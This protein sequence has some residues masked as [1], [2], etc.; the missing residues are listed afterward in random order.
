MVEKTESKV[1]GKKPDYK[2][3]GVAV[4]KNLDKNKKEFL[5]IKILNSITVRAFAPK[6]VEPE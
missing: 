1:V 4:W 3:D 5:A 6:D 2:G